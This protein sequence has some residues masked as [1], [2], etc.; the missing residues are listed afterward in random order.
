MNDIHTVGCMVAKSI[1]AFPIHLGLG[2]TAETEPQFTGEMQW[3]MD[4]VDRHANDG[5]EGRLVCMNTFDSS[6]GFWEM[7]PNGG[8]VVLCISGIIILHQ[9][10][11]TGEIHQTELRPGQYA[12]NH[13][14]VWHTADVREATTVVFITAGLG[15]QHRP[16]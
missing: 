7:H 13:P 3:Y 2:A 6:W 9:E 8:E 5:I 4:Y 14:G 12:I 10:D 1:T 16:R 11:S 15:T